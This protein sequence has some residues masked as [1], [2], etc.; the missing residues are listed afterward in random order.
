M[1]LYIK[2]MVCS[3]CKALVVSELENLGKEVITVELGLVEIYG[4]LNSK[5]YEH[6]KLAMQKSGLELIDD[7]KSLLVDKA[8]NIIIEM[9]S[10]SKEMPEKKCADVL[11]AK[12]NCNYVQLSDL[13]V[14]HTGSTI[15]SFII[16]TKVE[17]VKE[18][19]IQSNLSLT[20]ISYKLQYSSVSHLSN[21]FKKTTGLS[22]TSFRELQQEQTHNDYKVGIL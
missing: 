17:K 1:K 19:L 14:K 22:P 20:K 11:S 21:Q 13:F 7:Q 3:R 2:N 10:N 15:Q 5:A 9:I 4:D 18:L 6:F 16:A 8:K 12:L